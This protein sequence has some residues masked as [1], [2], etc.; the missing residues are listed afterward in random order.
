MWKAFSMLWCHHV[1]GHAMHIQCC[2]YGIC[3]NGLCLCKN[4]AWLHESGDNPRESHLWQSATPASC[5]HQETNGQFACGLQIATHCLGLGQTLGGKI[6][7]EEKFYAVVDISA[8]KKHNLL[9]M[10]MLGGDL[11]AVHSWVKI[12]MQRKIWWFVWLIG[13]WNSWMNVVFH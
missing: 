13:S 2:S 9:T 4:I 1:F 12:P 11:T 8:P 10:T 6:L 3:F 5:S 7:C